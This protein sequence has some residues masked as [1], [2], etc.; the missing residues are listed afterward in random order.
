VDPG[1]VF[2]FALLAAG[3]IAAAILAIF[4]FDAVWAR[5]GFGAAAIVLAIG[6]YILKRWNDRNAAR[7]RA[8]FESSR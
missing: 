4:V 2:K 8:K 6:I 5:A 1:A 7:Q 3:V